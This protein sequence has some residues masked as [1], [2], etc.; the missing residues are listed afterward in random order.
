MLRQHLGAASF[1]PTFSDLDESVHPFAE[2]RSHGGEEGVCAENEHATVPAKAAIGQQGRRGLKVRFFHKPIHRENPRGNFFSALHPA[3]SSGR[4]RRFDGKG[5]Q[6][7][8]LPFHGGVGGGETL[9]KRVGW[10]D[11]LIGSEHRQH[12]VWILGQH[13]GRAEGHRIH[14]V[15]GGRL[16]EQ[17]AG[18]QVREDAMNTFGVLRAG[19]DPAP[20]RG[21]STIKSIPRCLQQRGAVGQWQHLFGATGS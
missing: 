12:R 2:V 8:W 17:S 10:F 1:R 9:L 19:A 3:V 14:G 21:D 4:E 5:Q 13:G 7:F 15:A 20:L 6:G 16:S 18:C 11:D